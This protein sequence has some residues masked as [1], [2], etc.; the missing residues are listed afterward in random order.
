MKSPFELRRAA[1]LTPAPWKNGGGSTREIAA[2]PPGSSFDDFAWRASI[3]D[4]T[5]DGPFSRFAG[6]DRT[7]VLLSGN[8]MSL[9]L[10]ETR[11]HRLDQP[12]AP[13]AFRG[14]AAV[15]AVL[16]DGA[17]Q[18]SNLMIRRELADGGLTILHGAG[19]FPVD[20][21][22]RMLFVAQGRAELVD[23]R[24]RVG[25]AWHDTALLHG[26]PL[27]LALPEGAVVFAI[28]IRLRA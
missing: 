16:T 12:F 24:G 4:V 10:D 11:E 15:T 27:W 8:G 7:I 18:D 28:S 20:A 17:N 9:A 1:D 14:E 26:S 13:F 23:G 21:G 6:I 25:R 2:H 19:E 3:A 5:A 22:A